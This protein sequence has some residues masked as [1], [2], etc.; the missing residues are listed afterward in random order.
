MSQE[1]HVSLVPLE[2]TVTRLVHWE[3][4]TSHPPP[5][6]FSALYLSP[7]SSISLLCSCVRV[8]FTHEIVNTQKKIDVREKVF[9]SKQGERGADGGRWEEGI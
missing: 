7:L 6:T 8:R 5:F 9:G 4:P 2:H 1:V 3:D